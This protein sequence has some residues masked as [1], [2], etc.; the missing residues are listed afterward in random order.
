MIAT[1][2][3]HDFAAMVDARFRTYLLNAEWFF[4]GA[5][6]KNWH[7]AKLIIGSAIVNANGH[8][9]DTYYQLMPGLPAFAKSVTRGH[10][11]TDFRP[12]RLIGNQR[13]KLHSRTTIWHVSRCRRQKNNASSLPAARYF[14]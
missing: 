9:D 11:K 5:T 6:R 3:P 14:L 8:F 1:T 7:L 2:S 10:A 4:I 13:S 12:P